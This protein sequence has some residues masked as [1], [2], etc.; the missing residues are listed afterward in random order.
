[1]YIFCL[2]LKLF[3]RL[4]IYF[5]LDIIRL[6]RTYNLKNLKDLYM[7]AG[8]NRKLKQ[9]IEVKLAADGIKVFWKQ[10]E[11]YVLHRRRA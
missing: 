4:F 5:R 3:R 2:N 8:V 11:R 1:M 7:S 6:C 9:K 10:T